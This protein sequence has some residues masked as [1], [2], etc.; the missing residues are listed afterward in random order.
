MTARTIAADDGSVLEHT[1]AALAG[2]SVVAIPTDTVY[3]LAVDLR[4]ASAIERLFAL[5]GRPQEVP[6][7]VLVG[8]LDQV[9]ALAGRLDGPTAALA[10]R[11][12]PGPMTLVVARRRGVDVDLGGPE[13]SRATIGLRWPDH[14]LVAALCDR[15]GPLAVTSA[16]RH[17]GTPATTAAE[18]AAAFA[19]AD[20]L[21]VIVD[22]GRCT[23]R[24]STVVDCVGPEPTCLRDGAVSW[25]EVLAEWRSATPARRGA[26]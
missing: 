9:D 14:R 1:V 6:V 2:G 7:P 17:G 26:R 22:G 20:D 16:N 23:A 11:F 19:A 21:A 4:S 12:W 24:P 5:K 10:R 13:A 8:G 18:V 25:T 3:G 15:L